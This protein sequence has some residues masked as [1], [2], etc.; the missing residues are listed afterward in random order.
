MHILKNTFY[1][2]PLATL[3]DRTP[4][5]GSKC[6]KVL[7]LPKEELLLFSTCIVDTILYGFFWLCY[8]LTQGM[9]GNREYEIYPGLMIGITFSTSVLG[10]V[11]LNGY[12]YSAS[13]GT[14][15][16]DLPR[17]KLTP[18]TDRWDIKNIYNL[19]LLITFLLRPQ[20]NCLDDIDQGDS[21]AR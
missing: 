6:A 7:Y 10:F 16:F 8:V 15:C 9:E 14:R 13:P 21:L 1:V 18:N 20:E 2:R 19:I 11:C 4:V 3:E 17:Q 12:Y 5:S